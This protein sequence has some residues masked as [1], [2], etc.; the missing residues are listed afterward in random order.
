MRK[1]YD[2]VFFIW[3]MLFT[4]TPIGIILMWENSMFEKW[5]RIRA[6]AIFSVLF[7]AAIIQL[8]SSGI[9]SV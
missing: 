7:I 3:I 2:N 8:I 6:T 9:G 1:W 5:K 4:I